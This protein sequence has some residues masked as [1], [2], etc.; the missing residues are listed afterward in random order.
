MSSFDLY[1]NSARS[2]IIQ[3]TRTSVEDD[4][5]LLALPLSPLLAPDGFI[6]DPETGEPYIARTF[7][8]ERGTSLVDGGALPPGVDPRYFTVSYGA[9]EVHVRYYFY[10]QG[11]ERAFFAVSLLDSSFN[12]FADFVANVR[13]DPL[14]ILNQAT[15]LLQD[16][17][18]TF[19]AQYGEVD[20]WTFMLAGDDDLRGASNNDLLDSG[21]GDDVLLGRA[22]NDTLNGGAGS[23]FIDGGLGNDVIDGGA[24]L[25]DLLNYAGDFISFEASAPGPV[26]VTLNGSTAATVF[27]NGVAEDTVRNVERVQGSDFNDRI[28]GDTRE[29]LLLG[30]SGDD[31]LFGSGGNDTLFGGEGNDQLD[32]GA[33]VD[34]V[35]FTNLSIGTSFTGIG[36]QNQNVAV[37]LAGT[38]SATIFVNDVA[39]GTLV[40]VENLAGA[41]GNDTL[42]GDAGANQLSG[43]GSGEDTLQGA[44]GND[45]L[46]AEQDRFALNESDLLDGGAGID[47]V[48]W[49]TPTSVTAEF[50]NTAP[51]STGVAVTLNGGIAA[52]MIQGAVTLG[53]VIRVE[54]LVGG[55]GNDT[56]TGDSLVNRLEGRGGRDTLDG[57]GGDDTLIGGL[58][59]DVINGGTGN[60]LVDYSRAV[61]AEVLAGRTLGIEVTLNGATAATVVVGAGTERDTLAGVENLQGSVADDR[62]LGDKAANTLL[63]LGGNDT[64]LGGGGLDIL[65]GGAGFD[66]ASFA[67]QTG[68]VVVTLT[69]AVETQARIGATVLDTLRSI[70]NLVGGSGSDTFVGD[71]ARNR[72]A[73]GSGADTFSGGAGADLFNGGAGKDLIDGGTGVDTLDY[74]A[75]TEKIRV[76]LAGSSAAEVQVGSLLEDTVLNIE[77]V[78]GGS[79]ADSLVGDNNVNQLTGGR[80]D[81]VLDGGRGAD[82]LIGGARGL[83]DGADRFVFSSVLGLDGADTVVDFEV[84]TDKIVLDD[85]IFTRFAGTS[86]GVAIAAGNFRASSSAADPDDYLLFNA[87]EGSLSYDAD[88]SGPGFAVRIALLQ[89]VGDQALTAADFL[90]VS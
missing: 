81:D 37:T 80:G 25:T 59:N 45:I 41:S 35:E 14:F 4:F 39:S 50:F 69:G 3:S 9:G 27:V 73:G 70:E 61:F 2:L 53:T 10:D 13:G 47:T 7:K 34:L 5:F 6:D 67:D 66:T 17:T 29:N 79:A 86:Q 63:G 43:G 76:V 75:S 19:T 31:R 48:T 55:E 32:G 38:T 62:V 82:I 26:R 24:G 83:S 54:N 12:P 11:D 8:D 46:V 16:E 23:D 84:G 30:G 42:R 65:D 20:L 71:G 28:V 51:F 33:G 15:G 72:F 18:G 89:T 40:N 21:N 74:S 56:F 36:L 78:I 22:G 77:N 60:D 68:A 64:L 58:H 49:A 88:G 87:F 44:G 57:G 85:D 52:P 90:V 1:R